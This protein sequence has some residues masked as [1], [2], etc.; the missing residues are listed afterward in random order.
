MTFSEAG[1][2]VQC[3]PIDPALAI[4]E[5]LELIL[6]CLEKRDILILARVNRYFCD[7]SRRL[8][9]RDA[10][11]IQKWAE[12]APTK[13]RFLRNSV[14]V[15]P[16]NDPPQQS[17]GTSAAGLVILVRAACSI[18]FLQLGSGIL[19]TRHRYLQPIL[20]SLAFSRVRK[21]SFDM[22]GP[23][24]ELA[25]AVLHHSKGLVKLYVRVFSNALAR[26]A[27]P[28]L[29]RLTEAGHSIAEWCLEG[30]ASFFPDN[31]LM[32]Q[33]LR[34][35]D[36][37][38]TDDLWNK[39]SAL[40]HVETLE[41]C[42]P[43]VASVTPV[44]H[45]SWPSGVT[46]LNLQCRP[47]DAAALAALLAQP[48]S[49]VRR[50]SIQLS[51]EEGMG[52]AEDALK[53]LKRVPSSVEVLVMGGGAGVTSEMLQAV[54]GLRRLRELILFNRVGSFSM[55]DTT[56][57]LEVLE[58]HGEAELRRSIL[59]I[60][61]TAA[62]RLRSLTIPVTLALTD[63]TADNPSSGG[64]LKSLTV[65]AKFEAEVPLTM[66]TSLL[67]ALGRHA[68]NIFQTLTQFVVWA[69]NGAR[70]SS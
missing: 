6:V 54:I 12:L 50:M 62:P 52:A 14:V 24:L 21:I 53:L 61:R 7:V 48:P 65:A 29:R 64:V 18:T 42:S 41:L 8:F 2:D 66:R 25:Q 28:A 36:V 30:P 38:L 43:E 17:K 35:V 10:V 16:A 5:V 70:K 49:C 47:G 15:P 37:R 69:P 60:L 56:T 51:A 59:L 9:W 34:L 4:P 20:S 67:D 23:S 31:R 40:A 63:V 19:P 26:E 22:R 1:N 68:A 46:R 11:H 55:G 45:L 13:V 33:A 3:L 44:T 27:Y 57:H 39:L 58:L 32:V